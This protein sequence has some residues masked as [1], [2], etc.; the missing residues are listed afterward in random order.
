MTISKQEIVDAVIQVVT[1]LFDEHDFAAQNTQR[2]VNVSGDL[3]REVCVYPNKNDAYVWRGIFPLCQHDLWTGWSAL[4]MRY[5]REYGESKI[6]SA[7]ELPD[8]LGVLKENS[9][10]A[11]RFLIRIRDSADMSKEIEKAPRSSRQLANAYCLA[12]LG[13]IDA[14]TSSAKCFLKEG[15]LSKGIKSAEMLLKAIEADSVATFLEK[16]RKTNIRK[17]KLTHLNSD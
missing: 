14:A 6:V 9:E 5:P 16:N 11:L 15:E 10:K 2:F 8:A 4:G 17:L 7:Q 1:P 3:V 13:N 12:S